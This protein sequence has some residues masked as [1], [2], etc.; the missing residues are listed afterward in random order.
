MRKPEVPRGRTVHSC[1]ALPYP[2]LEAPTRDP[3]AGARIP[4]RCCC[5][6]QPGPRHLGEGATGG[7]L[8]GRYRL[9]GSLQSTGQSWEH[10][11]AAAPRSRGCAGRWKEGT[12]GA[13]TASQGAEVSAAAPPFRLRGTAASD[14]GV[15]PKGV[16]PGPGAPLAPGSLKSQAVSQ[17]SWKLPGGF[18]GRG[19]SWAGPFR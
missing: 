10:L 7:G 5:P 4:E 13:P 11:A 14:S 15:C 16:G 19:G 12:R 18:G 9:L 17:G 1:S 6:Q 8:A 3:E 2:N